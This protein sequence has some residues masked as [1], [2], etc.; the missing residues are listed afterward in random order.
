MTT[1]IP[2]LNCIKWIP[3]TPDE[4]EQYVSKHM[5]DHRFAATIQP[6]QEQ[7]CWYQP[8]MYSD[9]IRQQIISGAG[10]IRLR[11]FDLKGNVWYDDGFN[12]KQS[13]ISWPG[14]SLYE[15]D[16]ALNVVT[17]SGVYYLQMDIGKDNPKILVSEFIF[18][19]EKIE[20]TL[21]LEY[22]H[23]QFY[24]DVIFEKG[25]SPSIRIPGSIKPKKPAAKSTTYEDQFLNQTMLKRMPYD[26]LS[27]TIGGA[28]GVPPWLPFRKINWILGCSELKADGRF[29]TVNDDA[30]LEESPFADYPMSAWTIEVR[31]KFNRSSSVI[32][33]GEVVEGPIVAIANTDSKGFGQNS[34]NS[35]YQILDVN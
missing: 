14:M 32:E 26:I 20:N 7:V 17:E 23:H 5:D 30:E 18:I 28:E 2:Y 16:L 3:V 24:G 22:R 29:I 1:L 19:S 8:W 35:T 31:E 10:P 33:L 34:G 11:L 12:Q 27:M 4:V 21:L 25:F 6:W 15:N 9:S 13:I